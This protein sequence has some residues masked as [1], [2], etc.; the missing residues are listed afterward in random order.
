MPEAT[1]NGHKHYWEEAGSGEPLIMLHGAASSSAAL[2]MHLQGLARQFR[3]MMVDLR[4]LGRSSHIEK[5]TARTG[6]SPSSS[7][8]T[9]ASC[10]TSR[11][12]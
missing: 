8:S 4:G 12:T 1:I 9:I 11:S 10:P 2:I 7:I 5:C 3:V 6:R